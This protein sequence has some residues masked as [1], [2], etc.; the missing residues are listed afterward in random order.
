MENHA[1]FVCAR[2]ISA[3]LQKTGK[4]SFDGILLLRESGHDNSQRQVGLF[5]QA[6]G[7]PGRGRYQFL[8]RV[9]ANSQFVS[10][11]GDRAR[12]R[13]D[14]HSGRAKLLQQELLPGI[15]LKKSSQ[16]N[17]A[18]RWIAIDALVERQRIDPAPL[19]QVFLITGDPARQALSASP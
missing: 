15:Q 6:V 14:T 5:V 7:C 19:R 12:Q 16:A 10:G 1:L 4:N 9:G 3:G 17:I 18:D 8:F 11:P 13:R 2:Q